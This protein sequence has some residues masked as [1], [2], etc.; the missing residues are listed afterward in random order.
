MRLTK[1]ELEQ[2]RKALLHRRAVLNGFVDKMQDQALNSRGEAS[3]DFNHMADMGTDNYDQEFTLGL[4]ENEEDEV[5][6]IDKALEKID[7]GT[8]GL[9][10]SC[11]C[12]IPKKRL[13]AIPYARLC[14]RCKEAEEKKP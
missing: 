7:A 1:A 10:E 13:R 12:E 9:C 3:S 4:I 14:V 8:F 5:R 6:A 11:Q 2:F